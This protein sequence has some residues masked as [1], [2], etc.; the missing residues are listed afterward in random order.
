MNP[1]DV[2]ARLRW[3]VEVSGKT[4]N[5]LSELAGLDRTYLRLILTG[6]RTA[7]GAAPMAALAQVFGADLDWLL[8]GVGPQP[9]EESVCEAAERAKAAAD[10]RLA[11]D[12]TGTEG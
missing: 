10:Q 3:L 12:A 4:A 7:F 11:T 2:A 5:A 8:L 1:S 9:S 6:Q